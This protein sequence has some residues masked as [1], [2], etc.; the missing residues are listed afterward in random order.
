MWVT[1]LIWNL[2]IICYVKIRPTI[3]NRCPYLFSIS[4]S[5]LAIWWQWWSHEINTALIEWSIEVVL[6]INFNGPARVM[7]WLRW[8]YTGT[9]ISTTS[10]R[11]SIIWKIFRITRLQLAGPFNIHL[12]VRIDAD[13]VTSCVINWPN[14]MKSRL[15]VGCGRSTS[16]RRIREMV[17]ALV[18]GVPSTDK[19]L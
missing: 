17:R 11:A 6:P 18:N 9:I 1:L 5:A 15:M 4:K 7:Q 16:R 19:C 14:C 12:L 8:K 3:A 2:R 10:D 13:C